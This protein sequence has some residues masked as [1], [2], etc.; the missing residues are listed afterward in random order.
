MSNVPTRFYALNNRQIKALIMDAVPEISI[1]ELI[2]AIAYV[3]AQ[4]QLRSIEED[5][6][7]SKLHLL[8]IQLADRFADKVYANEIHEIR[9]RVNSLSD[10]SKANKA[11]VLGSLDA[12]C[13]K[14]ETI[15]ALEAYFG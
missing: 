6:L 15:D 8:V 9:E 12:I 7:T 1:Y 13:L 10:R 2:G 11:Q 3:R 14:Q 5:L 4:S